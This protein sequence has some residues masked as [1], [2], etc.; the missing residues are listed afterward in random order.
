MN[1][2]ELISALKNKDESAFRFLVEH[3]QTM[4][5]NA[6]YHLLRNN[7]DAQDIAQ[8]VFVEILLSISSFRAEAKL[9]T[10]LY[11]IAIN[12]SLNL[13]RKNRWQVFMNRLE[14]LL[15]GDKNTQPEIDDPSALKA[16]N[17]VERSEEEQILWS[18]INSL[19][20]NQRI[21]F[22]LNK[23]EELSYQEISNIMKTSISAIE[24]L[25]HRAKLN[26]QK[27]LTNLLEYG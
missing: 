15:P 24:S 23:Y 14:S 20:E 17:N 27:K 21:A 11:R 8:E 26:L 6:C 5:F 3:Y 19:P 2:L 18:A 10:W 7:E 9:S 1:D 16:I 22:T 12:K 25:I 13:L 4:V